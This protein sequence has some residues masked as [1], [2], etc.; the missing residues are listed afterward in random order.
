MRYRVAQII[1]LWNTTIAARY[2]LR[3]VVCTAE[4]K[5]LWQIGRSPRNNNIC[6]IRL[7]ASQ[8]E[9]AVLP[10]LGR[11]HPRLII[12]LGA[13]VVACAASL[14]ILSVR[15]SPSTRHPLVQQT[16]PSLPPAPAEPEILT[17]S[18]NQPAP[19]ISVLL[20]D[21]STWASL[22]VPDRV[23]TP[24]YVGH[25]VI[26]DKCPVP[27]RLFHDRFAA[28]SLCEAH[29]YSDRTLLRPMLLC[30]SR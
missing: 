2:S 6:S 4:L 3:S 12:A 30:S 22:D 17:W 24:N 27:C 10:M 7:V 19:S 14:F 11:G 29:L 28:C 8:G 20:W 25:D 5:V 16:L 13:L 9:P 1:L 26:K 23:P 18:T 15:V 21:Y